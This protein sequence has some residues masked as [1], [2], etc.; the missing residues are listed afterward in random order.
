MVTFVKLKRYF[1]IQVSYFLLSGTDV[2][3][4]SSGAASRMVRHRTDVMEESVRMLFGYCLLCKE[5]VRTVCQ[6]ER[7]LKYAAITSLSVVAS[8]ITS[9]SIGREERRVSSVTMPIRISS[10]LCTAM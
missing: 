5:C 2:C 1:S 6:S 8:V 10:M 3:V 7:E 9:S 4:L